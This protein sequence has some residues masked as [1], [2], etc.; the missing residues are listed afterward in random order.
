MSDQVIGNTILNTVL[1]TGAKAIKD[2]LEMT[3]DAA[4][5]D[6][7][8]FWLQSE[9]ARSF[10]VKQ[11]Y[12]VF[13]ERRMTDILRDANSGRKS[14]VVWQGDRIT[15]RVDI[16]LYER[17]PKSEDAGLKAVIELKKIDSD[18]CSKDDAIRIR[19]ISRVWENQI[20]G[21]VAGLFYCVSEDQA[22]S[23]FEVTE[24]RLGEVVDGSRIRFVHTAIE[25]DAR[26][27]HYSGIAA[28][29]IF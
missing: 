22:R 9:I 23:L 12:Y 1:Q 11:Q 10:A 29:Q 3:G 27:M 2:Y 18:Y 26:G 20:C 17:T 19:E 28:A 16:A 5:R 8:E 4:A 7:P 13:L 21:I 15:G 14:P 24:K 25:K 6:L